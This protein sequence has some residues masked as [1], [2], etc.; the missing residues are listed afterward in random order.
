LY[1]NVTNLYD[2]IS[3]SDFGIYQLGNVILD[4]KELKE[5]TSSFKVENPPFD[6]N[7]LTIE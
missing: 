5:S 2:I 6:M 4:I 1:N 3:E 7:L